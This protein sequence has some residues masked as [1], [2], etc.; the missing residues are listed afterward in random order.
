MEI[1]VDLPETLDVAIL[2]EAVR[3]IDVYLKHYKEGRDGTEFRYMK[4]SQLVR[5]DNAKSSRLKI[6]QEASEQLEWI[7]TDEPAGKSGGVTFREICDAQGAIPEVVRSATLGALFGEVHRNALT[8]L[9]E[10][11]EWRG[12]VPV[13]CDCEV[14][15]RITEE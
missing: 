9:L 11:I 6:M 2:Q 12:D 13:Y 7:L 10:Y 5:A 3:T 4:K 15:C 1:P 8:T 14:C